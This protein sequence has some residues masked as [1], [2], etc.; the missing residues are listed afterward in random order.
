MYL[1]IW[2]TNCYVNIPVRGTWFTKC[3]PLTE[4]DTYRVGQSFA[5]LYRLDG[6]LFI[7]KYEV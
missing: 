7:L 2:H 6:V 3:T 1:A 4:I 5:I